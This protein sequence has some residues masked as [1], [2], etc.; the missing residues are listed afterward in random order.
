MKKRELVRLA[1][2]LY[3]ENEITEL[4]S[5]IDFATEKHT[6]QKRKS[7]EPYIMHPLAVTAILIDWGMDIDTVLAG[8][9]HDTVED[10]EAS[11]RDIEAL[12]G[13]DVAF[14]VDG[15]TKVSK[16]RSGMRD[17]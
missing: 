6:G 14:L 2:A 4:I 13:R 16:A 7:G 17:L 10:T 1:S 11:L 3:T 12:F 9:L 5:A 15:V 8:V